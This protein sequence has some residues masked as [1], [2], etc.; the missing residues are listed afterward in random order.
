V[1]GGARARA[2]SADVS[3]GLKGPLSQ[4]HNLGKDLIVNIGGGGAEDHKFLNLVKVAVFHGVSTTLRNLPEFEIA[5]GN[6][7]LEFG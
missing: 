3:T 6:L 5:P 1:A 4:L 7:L 2:E